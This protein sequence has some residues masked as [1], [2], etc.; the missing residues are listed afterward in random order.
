MGKGAHP[1]CQSADGHVCQ[2]PSGRSCVEVPCK[3]VAGT[4]WG[5]YFCPAHDETRLNKIAQSLQDISNKIAGF[6]SLDE[7]E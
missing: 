7:K 5:P 4:F 2:K 3:E 1:N 6:P